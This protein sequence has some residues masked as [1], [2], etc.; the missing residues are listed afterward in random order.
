M[1]GF[2]QKGQLFGTA[3]KACLPY[4]MRQYYSIGAFGLRASFF[5]FVRL[6]RTSTKVWRYAQ[7]DDSK[8][9]QTANGQTGGPDGSSCLP[10]LAC[11]ARA[12][13]TISSFVNF[14]FGGM[15]AS[16]TALSIARSEMARSGY[17][18]GK[19]LPSPGNLTLFTGIDGKVLD[20]RTFQ[21]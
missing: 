6:R 19:P 10:A 3:K 5:Y 18:G 14:G 16:L 9:M 4:Q 7:K 12:V 1:P 8:I 11:R 21:W 20:A 15:G 13:L 17:R 2:R